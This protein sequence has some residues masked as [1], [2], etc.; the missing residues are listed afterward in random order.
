M[1]AR[2][3]C[4][5]THTNLIWAPRLA[6]VFLALLVVVP[7]PVSA[8]NLTNFTTVPNTDFAMFGAGGMRGQG[9]GSIVV[10]GLSGTVTAAYLFWH[11]PTND[12]ADTNAAVTFS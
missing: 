3:R 10:T 2:L 11:G 9:T 8:N 7:S 6:V 1:S 5:A 12:S 4:S